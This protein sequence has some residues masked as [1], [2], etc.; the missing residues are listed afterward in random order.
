MIYY[1]PKIF[2]MAGFDGAVSAIGAS[3]GVG[4]VNYCSR[5][6]LSIS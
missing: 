6:C 2:L 3:V 1:S 5:Y 4:V